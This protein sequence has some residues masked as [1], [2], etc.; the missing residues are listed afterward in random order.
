MISH[1]VLMKVN[2]A[3]DAAF[4]AAEVLG[5]R[6]KIPGLVSIVGGV[7]AI[8]S[9]TTWDLGFTMIFVDKET[10]ASYQSHPAHVE[11]GSKIKEMIREL[12][13]SDLEI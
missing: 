1:L 5:M 11:V 3:S 6:G 10:V 2:H 13:T 8:S 7:S 9:A 4:V 12:A